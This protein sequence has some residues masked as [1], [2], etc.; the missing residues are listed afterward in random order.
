LNKG[1]VETVAQQ[2]LDD[3][4]GADYYRDVTI[5]SV[6]LEGSLGL[7]KE[8][9]ERIASAIQ[10]DRQGA[11]FYADVEILSHFLENSK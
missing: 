7:A 6:F 10:G 8:K 1:N 5:L 4:R 11:D 3:R 2:I 9:A